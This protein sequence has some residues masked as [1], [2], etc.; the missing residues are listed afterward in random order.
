MLCWA[1]LASGPITMRTVD[2]RP[3]I[4]QKATDQ[5]IDLAA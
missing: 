5:T 1:P 3:T 2:R 4:A